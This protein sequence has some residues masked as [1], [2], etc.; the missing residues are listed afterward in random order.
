MFY[1]ITI[2]L[3]FMYFIEKY[4]ITELNCHLNN[5]NNDNNNRIINMHYNL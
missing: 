5:N 3:N 1:S 2:L 4:N